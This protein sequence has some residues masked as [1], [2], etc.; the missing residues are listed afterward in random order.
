MAKVSHR[1]KLVDLLTR[2]M[3]KEL[4]T[5]RTKCR[6]LSVDAE[7]IKSIVKHRLSEAE[8]VLLCQCLS[9]AIVEANGLCKVTA[10]RVNHPIPP[11]RQG[12]Y[13]KDRNY[14]PRSVP[15]SK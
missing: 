12:T 9:V 1:P 11:L 15:E 4:N 13:F 14:V 8:I 7:N 3:I 5:N 6:T 2:E 10:K